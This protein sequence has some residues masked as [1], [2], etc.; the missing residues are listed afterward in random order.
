MGHQIDTFHKHPRTFD[1][2]LLADSVEKVGFSAGLKSGRTT[3]GEPTCHIEWFLGSSL[4]F[5]A[6]SL[7]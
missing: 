6:L 1:R 4:T 2:P 5:A 7:G 3:I